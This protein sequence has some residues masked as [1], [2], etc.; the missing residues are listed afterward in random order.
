M[1]VCARH[2]RISSPRSRQTLLRRT[3][4]PV[5]KLSSW[6]EPGWDDAQVRMHLIRAYVVT[7]C[8]YCMKKGLF[9]IL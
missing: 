2:V 3:A 7:V 9:V 6:D 8:F 1:R 5:S 4:Q